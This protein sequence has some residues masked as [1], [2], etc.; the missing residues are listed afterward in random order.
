MTLAIYKHPG[1]VV[2]LVLSGLVCL[3]APRGIAGAQTRRNIKVVLESRQ[4]GTS[5]RTGAQGSGSIVVR[6]GT[7][8]PSGRIAA[9]NQQTTVERSSGIFTIVLD[10]GESLLTVATQVPQSEA[11]YY[12]NY[13]LGLGYIER[14][15]VFNDVGTSL[16]VGAAI[17]SDGQIRLRLTPRISYFSIDRP[18]AIDCT[19][20]A[21]DLIVRNG[22]AI[23]VGGSTSKLHE[24]TRQI[25]GYSSR[26]STDETDLTVTAT[27]Q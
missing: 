7:V 20:A 21:T 15:I 18:G 3:V 14:H 23:P 25:L 8:Y 17:L 13:A 6:R 1:L 11:A 22:E 26:S 4:S 27:V 2:A 24:V 16:R 5:N 9:G 19:E 12:F 10:G